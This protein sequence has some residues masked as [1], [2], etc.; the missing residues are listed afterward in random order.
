MTCPSC[1]QQAE[2]SDRYCPWCG[3]PLL[4]LTGPDAPSSDDQDSATGVPA[5]AWTTADD[6]ELQRLRTDVDALGT[7]QSRLSLRLSN[8]ERRRGIQRSSQQQTPAAPPAPETPSA[9]PSIPVKPAETAPA[10]HRRH[11]PSRRPSALLQGP[12]RHPMQQ[13]R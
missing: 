2:D 10:K 13:P 1:G 4:A 11:P 8:L 3:E 12:R 7:E 6:R 5:P 9:A